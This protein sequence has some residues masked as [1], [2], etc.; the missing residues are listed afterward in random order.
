LA[1]RRCF[2]AVLTLAAM[3][4][5]GQLSALAWSNRGH[6]MINLAAAQSL[7]GDIPSFMRTPEAIREIAYLGPEPDR[8]TQRDLEPE[9]ALATEPDHYFRLELA[10]RIGPLPRNRYEFL[11]KLDDL[12]R[13]QPVDAS[14]FTVKEIGTLPWQAEEVFG[15]LE[16]A[17]HNYRIAMGQYSP[18]DYTE[19]APITKDDLPDIEASAVFYS[20]WLGHYIGDGCMPLH[21]SINIAGWVEKKNPQG[22]TTKGAIHHNFEAI[23]DDAI[24]KDA[25]T[26]SSVDAMVGPVRQLSDPFV[27]TLAYLQYENR[28]VE[29][30]YRLD[31]DGQL[32]A[33]SP[34]A[35]RFIEARMADGSSM[36][37]DLIYTA[38]IDSSSLRGPKRPA[39]AAIPVR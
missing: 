22:Y 35:Q 29:D 24:E 16:A 34:E 4:A 14:S 21:T 19:W 32:M 13:K 18:K 28:F 7:P 5:L 38:W 31:K 15:R 11:E 2:R 6:R 8:W 10:E 39:E 17:F 26:S 33:S 27:D 37:R 36:L 23:A 25:I 9:L 30:V 1:N 3:I 20:G 12:R